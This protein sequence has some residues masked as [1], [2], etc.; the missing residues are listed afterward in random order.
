M[1][2]D[3]TETRT[4]NGDDNERDFEEDVLI[5][6]PLKRMLMLP[7]APQSV[8][9]NLSVKSSRLDWI[10]PLVLSIIISLIVINVGKDFLRNDQINAA[11]QRIEN[12]THLTDEDKEAQIESIQQAMEKMAGFQY[13][14]VNVSTVIGTVLWLIVVTLVLMAVS[15]FILD[16]KLAFGDGL[17][18][19]ALGMVITMIGSLVRLPIVFYYESYTQSTVSLGVLF[20]EA[21]H[22][23]FFIKLLDIDIFMLWYVI[24]ISIGLSVFAKKSLMKALIPILI[25]WLVFR[26][27]TTGITGF[28]SGLGA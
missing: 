18:I 23:N 1:T 24:V 28:M 14:M 12:N 4:E 22:D 8:F 20:P 7:F 26:I 10:I 5:E 3:I 17:T 15:R 11:V 9:K 13:V 2:G 25:L 16:K 19:G 21:M 27:I 6:N